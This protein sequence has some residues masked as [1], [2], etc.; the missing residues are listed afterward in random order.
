[1]KKRSFSGIQPT[2]DI[3]IGNYLAAIRHWA[4]MQD[5]FDNIFCIV[6]MHAITVPQDPKVLK[7]KVRAILRRRWRAAQSSFRGDL[8]AFPLASLLRFCETQGLTGFVDFFAGDTLLSLRFKAGQIDDPAAEATLG[9]L[10][11]LTE[12][13]FVVHSAAVDFLVASE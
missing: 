10:A 5:N 2:G 3:H 7:A 12:A 11:E 9:R 6:D 4:A 1:M 13:P 8:G